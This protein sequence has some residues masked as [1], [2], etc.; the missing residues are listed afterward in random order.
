MQHSLDM[1]KSMT[2]KEIVVDGNVKP[3]VSAPSPD[4]PP[5]NPPDQVHADQKFPSDTVFFSIC[6]ASLTAA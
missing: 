4:N 3:N 2:S 6:I 5:E 1:K